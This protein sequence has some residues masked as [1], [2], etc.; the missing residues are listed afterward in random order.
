MPRMRTPSPISP[1]L[2]RNPT[3]GITGYGTLLIMRKL[4]PAITMRS[5]WCHGQFAMFV[6]A[7]SGDWLNQ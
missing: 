4:S 1:F 2:V 5:I 3:P 6:S 7:Y